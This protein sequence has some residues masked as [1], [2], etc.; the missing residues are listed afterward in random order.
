MAG[1]AKERVQFDSDLIA[2]VDPEGVVLHI[3]GNNTSYSALKAEESIG[4]TLY[5]I[6]PYMPEGGFVVMR[7][8]N[9]RRPI[10]NEYHNFMVNGK[11]KC[12]V[13]SGFPLISGGRLIG[14]IV[15]SVELKLEHSVGKKQLLQAQYRFEDI[16]TCDPVFSEI[17]QRLEYVSKYDSNVLLIG[18]T[19]T[20]KELLAHAIHNGSARQKY[21]FLIQSCAAIPENIMES[22]LFGATKGS[23]TGAVDKVG[24][25]E[26]ACGGT[27]CLDEI[28][29]M[30][31]ALQSKLLRALENGSIRRIG[32]TDERSIDV[33]IIASANEDLSELVA[34]GRFRADLYYRL[35]VVSVHIPPLRQ[36][37]ADILPLAK[38]YINS[39]NI[40]FHQRITGLDSSSQKFFLEYSLS[41]IHI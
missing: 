25:L 35:N 23:Y 26:A 6:Y 4:K 11:R 5:D 31:F 36:R 17:L 28:N 1:L 38:R 12:T 24:L 20:G 22:I 3:Y 10:L 15:F 27:I 39:F 19:G 2:V 34:Q 21:P 32:E 29:S 13:N 41:L 37:T 14:G 33:R 30:P 9:Q 16:F 8:M 40:R 7:A 18:E